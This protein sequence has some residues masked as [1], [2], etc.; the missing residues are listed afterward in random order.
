MGETVAG[1]FIWTLRISEFCSGWY[2]FKYLCNYFVS[3][4]PSELLTPRRHP[5][6]FRLIIAGI[7][8]LFF[9]SFQITVWP[10]FTILCLQVSFESAVKEVSEELSKIAKGEYKT[11]EYRTPDSGKGKIGAIVFAAISLPVTE[12]KGLLDN[13]ST[14]F[15]SHLFFQV[16]LLLTSLWNLIQLCW[17]SAN[18]APLI[19]LV[20]S[21]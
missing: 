15:L 13:V 16:P 21:T 3:G 7:S 14:C 11:P 1:C 18:F 20:V 6:L 8:F 4:L 19:S 5:T 17:I 10:F 2:I 9:S 12:I